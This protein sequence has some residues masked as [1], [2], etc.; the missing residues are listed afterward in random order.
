[1][2]PDSYQHAILSDASYA[3]FEDV[4]IY[5]QD[6]CQ[7]KFYTKAFSESVKIYRNLRRI[8]HVVM[9]VYCIN[10]GQAWLQTK[11]NQQQCK[12]LKVNP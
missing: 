2:I 5:D 12:S 6:D 8:I 11:H 1:M 4:D 7:P 9:S 3:D 10:I